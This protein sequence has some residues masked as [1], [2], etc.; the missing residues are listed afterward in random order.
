MARPLNFHDVNQSVLQALD[1][2]ASTAAHLARQAELANARIMY[3]K[4]GSDFDA[5][6]HNSNVA[7][8]R[9]VTLL[10]TVGAAGVAGHGAP[11]TA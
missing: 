2:G 8:D 11:D 4:A 3:R 1:E 6:L 9:L 5:A 7:T 10:E